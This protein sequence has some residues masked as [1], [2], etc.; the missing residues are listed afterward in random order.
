MKKFVGFVAVFTLLLVAVPAGAALA[1]G[2]GERSDSHAGVRQYGPFV[3]GSTDS[4]TCGNDWANDTYKRHFIVNPKSP[5]T[6]T[7]EFK[8]GH[9]ITVAGSSPGACGNG[10]VGG[11]L[12][13][14]VKGEFKGDFV[15]TVTGGTYN[16]NAVC[17]QSTCN[18][19]AKF[20]A[21]VYGANAGYDVPSFKF[22]YSAGKNGKWQNA[23]VDRGGNKGDI[24]GVAKS[25]EDSED[26]D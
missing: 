11:L 3:S 25:E 13:A 12:G 20:I 18:T 19:T 4:G 24:T 1:G 21:T 2:A 15:I 16:P 23:S 6:L 8:D 26:A 5:Y 14:G 17:T 9:F 22:N 10:V 7:E